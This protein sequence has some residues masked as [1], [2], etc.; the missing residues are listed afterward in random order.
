MTTESL[1][2]QYGLLLRKRN[3]HG[4]RYVDVEVVSRKPTTDP[5]F[6]EAPLGVSDHHSD[7]ERP[8]HLQGHALDGLGFYGFVSEYVDREDHRCHF[9]GDHIEHR[10]VHSI[11]ERLARRIL[12]T[13]HH[14]NK[15]LERDGA[16]EPGDKLIALT[17][18]LKLDFVV[19]DR[20]PTRSFN[21]NPQA[22]WVYYSLP[23]GRDRYR[24]MIAEEEAT[25][26]AIRVPRQKETA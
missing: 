1:V 17:K 19:E 3:A 4:T 6:R 15:R 7:Y 13:L 11:D 20:S 18:A 9:I 10:N 22:R 2:R 25:E 23:A 16:H 5:D 24:Q 26:T 14:V 21:E 8:K 12:K